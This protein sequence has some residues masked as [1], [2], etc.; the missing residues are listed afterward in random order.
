MV[1]SF[2]NNKN[3]IDVV[4]IDTYST[5]NFWYAVIIGRLAQFFKIPYMPILHGGNLPSRLENNPNLSHRLFDN[6]EI[7]ISPSHYLLEKFKSKGYSN[8]TYIP[9]TIEIEQYPFQLRKNITAKLLWVRSFSEIYNPELALEVVRLLQTSGVIV[10]LCMV[11][12]E[13]DGSQKKCR[14]IVEKE[15][16]PVTFTGKL[17]K[18]EW[19]ELSK[20]FDIF[21]NTTNFDNMPVSVME[22]MAL[23]FPII[24]TN[25]GGIP[26]LIQDGKDGILVESNNPNAFATAISSLLTDPIKTENLSYNARQKVT[27]FDWEHVK[28]RWF[29]LLD[30]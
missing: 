2:F 23:G 22:A 1:N 15:N 26:Y 18:K 28:Q 19:I 11:G 13:K 9:N 29:A 24:S 3:R 4:L 30:Q 6:A 27:Q 7:N 5:Q 25:V 14:E 16:L 12:P 21:I 10:S 17:E 8:L 20:D